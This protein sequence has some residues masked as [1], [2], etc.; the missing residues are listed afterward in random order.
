VKF[1]IEMK[2]LQSHRGLVHYHQGRKRRSV[3]A[4]MMLEEP[5][6]LHLNLQAA[7]RR[8]SLLH[9]VELEH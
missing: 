5:R 7:K 4:I 3:P 8:V 9:W 2:Y 1:S 6:I